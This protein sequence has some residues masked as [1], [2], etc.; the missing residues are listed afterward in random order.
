M[1]RTAPAAHTAPIHRPPAA[2]RPHADAPSARQ[3]QNPNPHASATPT[4]H[5]AA[6][7]RRSNRNS[8]LAQPNSSTMG[9]TG[10][11]HPRKPSGKRKIRNPAAQ[12]PA[13]FAAIRGPDRPTKPLL[14]PNSPRS[15]PLGQPSPSRSA[16]RSSPS[17]A[18]QERGAESVP[19]VGPPDARSIAIQHT[20]RMWSGSMGGSGSGVRNGSRPSRSTSSM[21]AAERWP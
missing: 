15:C 20:S 5:S 3:T 13:H 12:N 2:R 16:R 6:H 18:R 9:D 19:T 11:E 10:L 1:S 8:L 4:V 7:K 17:Y 14:T 21:I